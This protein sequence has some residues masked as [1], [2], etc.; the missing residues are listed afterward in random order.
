MLFRSGPERSSGTETFVA[1]RL[2]IANWRWAGVPFFLRTGKRL[3]RKT[4]EIV[5]QFKPVPHSMFPGS[6]GQL[7]A[8]RLVVRL[9]PDEGITLRLMTKEP[10]PGGLRLRSAPLDLSFAEAFSGRFPEA[11]ERLLMDVVRGNATLFMRRDEVETA[12]AFLD[13]VLRA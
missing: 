9:Q 2:A 4:S 11:Y 1:L 12:W 13:P 3:A 6:V 10:G 5:I 7:A 8:N